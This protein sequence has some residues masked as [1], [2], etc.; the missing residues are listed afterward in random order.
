MPTT[1]LRALHMLAQ[2]S[3]A[4]EV[5]TISILKMRILTLR[6]HTTPTE[7]YTD[8]RLRQV[9]ESGLSDFSALAMCTRQTQ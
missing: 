5:I 7:S 1:F 8:E 4:L 2:N 6:N 9:L 3:E